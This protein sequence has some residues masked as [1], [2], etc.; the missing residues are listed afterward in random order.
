MKPLVRH[1]SCHLFWRPIFKY[2]IDCENFNNSFKCCPNYMKIQIFNRNN[3]KYS[4]E[5]RW[6]SKTKR[7]GVSCSSKKNRR[8]SSSNNPALILLVPCQILTEHSRNTVISS[9]VNNHQYQT[10]GLCQVIL[11][12]ERVSLSNLLPLPFP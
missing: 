6:P 7:V 12:N 10:Q 2:K 1:Q 9:M 4:E 3:H 5:E 8:R 11:I